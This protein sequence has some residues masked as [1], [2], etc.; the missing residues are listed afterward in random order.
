[1]ANYF[2][3]PQ[4]PHVS[5]ISAVPSSPASSPSL[6]STDQNWGKRYHTSTIPLPE[7]RA[8]LPS[9]SFN[10]DPIM[11]DEPSEDGP[12][13]TGSP[14]R[15]SVRRSSL[16][17]PRRTKTTNDALTSKENVPPVPST[18]L[19]HILPGFGNHEL[20]HKVL[21]CF[22]VK[23]DGLMRVSCQTVRDL[24]KGHFDDRVSGFQI[25]DCRFAY[26]HE[27][28]HTHDQAEAG[29]RR[30]GPRRHLRGGHPAEGRAQVRRVDRPVRPAAGAVRAGALWRGA[31]PPPHQADHRRPVQD[32]S[33]RRHPSDRQRRDRPRHLLRRS[34]GAARRG[35]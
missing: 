9:A 35:S 27:G 31:R 34:A 21:P 14:V 30:R 8:P 28:G 20:E 24:M 32:P 22:P 7:V 19:S 3:D 16:S 17:G 1:M 15:S 5:M 29:H 4:S 33:A 13:Q 11:L 18:A 25:V 6:T 26:E 10:A 12:V 23:S 2:Y